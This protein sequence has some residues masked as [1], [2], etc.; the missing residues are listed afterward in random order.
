MN[1]LTSQMSRASEISKEIQNG[2]YENK[3][4]WIR[5]NIHFILSNDEINYV[6]SA[7]NIISKNIDILT[8]Q[9]F[10]NAMKHRWQHL[11]YDSNIDIKLFQNMI[12]NFFKT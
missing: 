4:G 11:K 9:H 7:I 6:L 3:P 5:F 1:Y 12:F 10:Y 8:T 2:N